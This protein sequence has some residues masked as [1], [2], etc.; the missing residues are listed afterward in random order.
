[1]KMNDNICPFNKPYMTGHELEYIT[2]ANAYGQFAGD[3][4]TRP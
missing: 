2:Q 3:G 1:M 4:G